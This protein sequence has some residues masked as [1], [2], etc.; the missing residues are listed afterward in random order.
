MSF[1]LFNASFA[2]RIVTS[3]RRRLR[4]SPLADRH[5]LVASVDALVAITFD[6]AALLMLIPILYA[7]AR[8]QRLRGWPSPLFVRSN[9]PC[10]TIRLGYGHYTL[11]HLRK[12]PLFL[13]VNRANP[14]SPC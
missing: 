1:A 4:P 6:I 9:S 13:K 10:K 7:G 8:Q 2:L 5:A 12:R 3:V 14:L 11:A